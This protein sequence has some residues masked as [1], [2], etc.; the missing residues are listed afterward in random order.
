MEKLISEL[1]EILEV[2]DLPLDYRFES[3]AEWDSLNALSVIAMLDE[4]Y[5]IQMDAEN[6]GRFTSISEF[7]QHVSG[8]KK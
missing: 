5:G 2:S 6:L 3:L 7:I 8:H 1:K 4:Q